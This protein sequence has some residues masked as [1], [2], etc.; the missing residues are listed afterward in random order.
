MQWYV[1]RCGICRHASIAAVAVAG[2]LNWLLVG[3]AVGGVL[4]ALYLF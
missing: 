1:I 2:Q 3:G 4:L